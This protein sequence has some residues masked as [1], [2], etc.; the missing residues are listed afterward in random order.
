[1]AEKSGD[2]YIDVWRDADFGGESTRIHGPAEYPTLDFKGGH[3]GDDIGSLR[4][5]PNAFVMAYQRQE[6]KDELVTFGPNDEV[7]DLSQY[8]FDDEI[9]SLKVIDSLKIFDR[10]GYNA[11]LAPCAPD[12]GEEARP[13]PD[14]GKRLRGKK[15]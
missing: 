2:C 14:K 12:A 9:E 3:W 4:V 11:G 10:V 6:F 7:A 1:M 5:G 8:K 15:R 13:G